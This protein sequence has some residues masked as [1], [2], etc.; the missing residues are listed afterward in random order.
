[1]GFGDIEWSND[2]IVIWAA[3]EKIAVFID[4]QVQESTSAIVPIPEGLTKAM[5]TVLF[6]DQPSAR[7]GGAPSQAAVN[8]SWWGRVWRRIRSNCC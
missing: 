8:A 4:G 3:A 2:G 6:A 1:M 7:L 5:L